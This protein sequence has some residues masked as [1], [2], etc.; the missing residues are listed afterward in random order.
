MQFTSLSI[1]DI[2]FFVILLNQ[3]SAKFKRK[4]TQLGPTLGRNILLIDMIACEMKDISNRQVLSRKK[5]VA[6]SSNQLIDR[7]FI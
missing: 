1:L 7:E 2:D 3:Y 5:K 4:S 6:L